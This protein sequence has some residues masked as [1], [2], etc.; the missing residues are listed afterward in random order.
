MFDEVVGAYG[1][2]LER[3]L[4]LGGGES[5]DDEN[6]ETRKKR[7][8]PV[9]RIL[10]PFK[11]AANETNSHQFNMPEYLG[12][13][14]V[15]VVAN[16]GRAYG[17]ADEQVYVREAVNILPTLPRSASP[18]EQLVVPTL[19]FRN[20]PSFDEVELSVEVL[21]G[22]VSIVGE[23]TITIGFDDSN[24]QI[25][26][27]NIAVGKSL[28]W[29]KI[30][31]T[32]RAGDYETSSTIDLPIVSATTPTTQ[33]INQTIAAGDDW[34]V[35]ITPHGIEG[36]NVASLT[37]SGALPFNLD[38][39]LNYL[40]RYPHGCIEQTTSAAFPQLY[41]N[42]LSNLTDTQ[43][44][45]IEKNISRALTRLTSFQTNNGGFSYWPGQSET[46]DWGTNYA[47]HF[48]IAAMEAGYSVPDELFSHWLDYQAEQANNWTASNQEQSMMSQAYRLYTLVLANEADLA[49]MNRLRVAPNLSKTA[50]LILAESYH[51][52]GLA[53]AAT[54][55]DTSLPNDYSETADRYTYG[56]S[57]RNQAIALRSAVARGD[58]AQA[59]QLAAQLG[60]LMASDRWYSTQTVAYTLLAFSDYLA[61]N[62]IG[63]E[64]IL[65]V[66]DEDK[67]TIQSEKT[68][69]TSA[70]SS[71]QNNETKVRVINEMK[72]PI[73]ASVSVEG[74]PEAGD[75]VAVSNKLSLNLQWQD[76]Q[77]NPLQSVQSLQQGQDPLPGNSRSF[78]TAPG[79]N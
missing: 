79:R 77:Q 68:V 41:L 39:R 66:A 12:Q 65:Q 36:T 67:V 22:D 71:I 43:A 49:A 60:E 45:Q 37:L 7:F 51:R 76:A 1:G 40:I 64:A 6:A 57:M 24:E 16:E 14:R 42:D 73:Y 21:E 58:D 54:S 3:L 19:V 47:G 70:L 25:T 11:L 32:A 35:D 30:Q 75:E 34:T 17:S 53:D 5:E 10:G 26:L 33:I 44:E 38:N 69:Y 2:E 29:A 46:N 20:D 50:A 61:G 23:P 9:V 63:V 52:Y 56:S 31:I 59:E 4:A 18:G 72:R 27:F 74:L 28:E 62:G 13:V 48:M 15:M 55:I 78:Q 8:P